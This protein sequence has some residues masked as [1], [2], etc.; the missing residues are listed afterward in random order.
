M[1]WFLRVLMI[2]GVLIL[3]MF[4]MGSTLPQKHTATS[5][6]AFT[7]S[8]EEV[9]SVLTRFEEWPSWRTDLKSIQTG[10]NS[11][12]EVNTDGESVEYQIDEFAPNERL[13]TRI[14]TPDLPYGGSWT[15]EL[16]QAGNGCTLTITENGEVYN[17]LF[18]FMSK[19]MFGHTATMDTYLGS[20][21]KR[22]P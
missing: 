11:F 18:R 19:Y 8:R 6:L 21:K 7:S 15:Y 20:L 2:L 10:H 9:W 22:I 16:T 1:K 17:P 5:S 4:I 3:L 13:I 12:T 14:I